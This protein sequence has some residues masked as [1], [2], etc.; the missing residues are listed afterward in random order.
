MNIDTTTA[1]GCLYGT[2]VYVFCVLYVLCVA[3][4]DVRFVSFLS[5]VWFGLLG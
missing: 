5:I 4:V 3:I 1:Q 2:S